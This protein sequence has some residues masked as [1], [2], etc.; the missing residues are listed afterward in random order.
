MLATRD[1][2]LAS[3]L[4][5]YRCHLIKD[6]FNEIAV[7]P[8]LRNLFPKECLY[9]LTEVWLD[10]IRVV[11]EAG[12]QVLA[13]DIQEYKLAQL[14]CL[15]DKVAVEAC[16]VARSTGSTD[17]ERF[18]PGDGFA[19]ERTYGRFAPFSHCIRV[20]HQFSAGATTD[21]G[22]A[23]ADGTG[24]LRM[25]H[26][27]RILGAEGEHFLFPGTSQVGKESCLG[28][29]LAQYPGTVHTFA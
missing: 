16:A 17:D 7:V 25:N 15:P 21:D 12:E 22:G 14:F 27:H 10:D 18:G 11:G 1:D 23:G 28:S 2:T 24:A 20:L 6:P 9:K 29:K 5:F 4:L 3:E 26:F 13:L 8:L 19:K